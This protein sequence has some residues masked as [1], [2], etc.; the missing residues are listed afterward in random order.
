MRPQAMYLTHYSRVV[1]VD[2]LGADLHRPFAQCWCP[3]RDQRG[4][5]SQQVVGDVD[6]HRARLEAR[7]AQAAG[8]GQVRVVH[9][10]PQLGRQHRADRPRIH[11]AVGV[12][13]ARLAIDRA[14]VEA[15]PAPDA[16]EQFSRL[17]AQEFRPPS[18]HEDHVRLLGAVF[19]FAPPPRQHRRVH[20]DGL[21][22]CAPR[23]QFQKQRQF[24]HARDHLLDP[25]HRHVHP[26]ARHS[27]VGVPFVRAQHQPARLRQQ[28]VRPRHAEIGPVE[29]RT[30][31]LSRD[32]RE[33]PRILRVRRRQLPH[34]RPRHAPPILVDHRRHDVA[35]GV[36]VQLHNELA[37]VRLERRDP[38]RRQ[39]RQQPRLLRHHRLALD[40]G[41]ASS[42]LR[43]RQTDLVR[44]FRCLG[45]VHR[46]ARRPCPFD[47]QPQIVVEVIQRVL[48]DLTRK[49]A[50]I[51][52]AFAERLLH[53]PA[54]PRILRSGRLMHKLL[55]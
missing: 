3:A 5:Q 11:R 50:E 37:K 18:I 23:E 19:T 30:H 6:R 25:D 43:D 20:R 9:Q 21:G 48:F 16:S 54:P 7:P 41:R 39:F 44:L 33:R 22:R 51:V 45:D 52:R 14:R 4:S 8:V 29:R 28:K 2:R 35:R 1:D 38:R 36:P 24:P 32:H 10:P 27:Q 46:R 15:R 26:R 31:V 40:A 53:R 12:P 42:S 47:P 34:E 17:F 13:S 55:Q 49:P